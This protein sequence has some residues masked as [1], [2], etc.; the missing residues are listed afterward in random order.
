MRKIRNNLRNG[1]KEEK[2]SLGHAR[3]KVDLTATN[4]DSPTA[5]SPPMHSGVVCQKTKQKKTF[6]NPKKNCFFSFAKIAISS[7]NT[8]LKSMLFWS[9]TEGKGIDRQTV[10]TPFKLNRPR[11]RFCEKYIMMMG[12][13]F[14]S[15]S[16]RNDHPVH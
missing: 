6:E 14:S 5:N 15:I 2:I 12:G 8:S 13:K 16:C 1:K 10:I 7:L 11:G 4:T 3:M 9:P